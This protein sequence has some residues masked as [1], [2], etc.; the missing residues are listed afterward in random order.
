[1][2]EET[3]REELR[4]FI[5][6]LYKD[7]F[8]YKFWQGV[9][10]MFAWIPGLGTL[11]LPVYLSSLILI[12]LSAAVCSLIARLVGAADFFSRANTLYVVLSSLWVWL[13]V[14]I[15]KW[16]ITR[17]NLSIQDNLLNMMDLP[18]SEPPL[19]AWA[20]FA[21]NRRN[22]SIALILYFVTMSILSAIGMQFDYSQL[23]G[24]ILSLFLALGILYCVFFGFWLGAQ[25]L[26]FG[27][28]FRRFS[29]RLFPDNPSATLSLIALHRSAGQLMLVS[30]LIAALALPVGFFTTFLKSYMVVLSALTLWIPLLAFYISMESGFSVHIRAAKSAKISELQEQISLIEKRGNVRDVETAELLQRMLEM[31]EAVRRTPNSL[32]NVESLGN[33]LGSLALPLLGGVSKLFEFWK[34][35]FGTP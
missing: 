6:R 23:T 4:Q 13:S 3:R 27:F 34:Q 15:S 35:F 16:I 10:R 28:Y 30:V 26:F 32:V 5:G 29:L 24:W 8:A 31:H 19:M 20:G 25:V 7:S 33:L 1:M 9:G 12:L 11:E 22:Q 14:I 2:S 17:T 21:F 18:E